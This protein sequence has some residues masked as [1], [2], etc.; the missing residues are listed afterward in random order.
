MP[1]AQAFDFEVA[2][3]PAQAAARLRARVGSGSPLRGT[4]S[5]THFQLSPAPLRLRGKLRPTA[6]GHLEAIGPGRTRVVG[7][8]RSPA[9]AVWYFRIVAI[10]FPVLLGAAAWS[11]GP[12]L[13]RLP[14]LLFAAFAL[15][16]AFTGIG[17][18]VWS[19]DAQVAPLV[20]EIQRACGVATERRTGTRQAE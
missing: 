14:I 16:M 11:V 15:P 10:V 2:G 19:S 18:N 1:R 13:E 3:T 5:D 7:G 8:C 9:W 17:F 6:T 20:E 12:G 4:V